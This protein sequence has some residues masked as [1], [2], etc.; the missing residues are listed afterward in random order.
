MEQYEW[1][2][3]DT[4]QKEWIERRGIL[5]WLAEASNGIGGGLFLVSL[6]FNNLWGMLVSWLLVILLKGGF[7]FAYLGKPL[8]FWRM[9]INPRTSWLA[10]G[11]I[12]LG[13]FIV[14]GA[15]QLF[16]SYW[17]PGTALETLFKIIAGVMIFLVVINTGFVMNCIKAI[18]LW[19]SAILP[20]LFIATGVLDGL[21]LILI[22][23]LSGGNVD[24]M[25]A[26]AGSRL[27]LIFNAFLIAT[28]LWG[29]AY[30][31]PTGKQSVMQLIKGQTAP[32]LWVGVILCGIIIPFVVSMYSYFADSLSAPLLI[33]AVT[34]EMLGAF[35]LKYT[36]LKSALYSPLIPSNV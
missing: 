3:K 7:H 24:I 31:G 22:I 4:P 32:I 18:P 20:L 15:I 8:R 6:Y 34:C 13:L 5:I 1:M 33:T 2:V 26:E 19:N 17:F 12:F 27:L 35:S 14:L 23:G 25:T 10:R 16:F 21:A 29:S 36:I 9:A 28:Y 11:F 30:T